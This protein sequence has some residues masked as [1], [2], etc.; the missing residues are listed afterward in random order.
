LLP[1]LPLTAVGVVEVANTIMTPQ[2]PT[3]I[4]AVAPI[5]AATTKPNPPPP[6][7]KPQPQPPRP[8][9]PK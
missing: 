4:V 2:Q 7:P 6:G 8:T 5:K 9:P 1:L 3:A